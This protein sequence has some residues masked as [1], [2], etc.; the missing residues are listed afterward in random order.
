[1]KRSQLPIFG[2]DGG[3]YQ[4]RREFCQA[5]KSLDCTIACATFELMK[6]RATHQGKEYLIINP[7]W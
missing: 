2:V 1:M 5:E 3:L 6:R 7:K 4:S